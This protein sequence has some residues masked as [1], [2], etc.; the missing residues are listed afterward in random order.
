MRRAAEILAAAHWRELAD[1]DCDPEDREA[2]SVLD[3]ALIRKALGRGQGDGK[4]YRIL[5]AILQGDVLVELTDTPALCDL[6]RLEHMFDCFTRDEIDRAL[7]ALIE[8]E[9]GIK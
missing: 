9:E 8:R 1:C 6:T 5:R 3:H 7:D 4:R 2:W